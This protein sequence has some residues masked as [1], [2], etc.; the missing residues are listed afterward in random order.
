MVCT[1]P[2][3][4]PQLPFDL[5][6]GVRVSKLVLAQLACEGA[7]ALAVWCSSGDAAL[8]EAV[9]CGDDAGLAGTNSPTEQD[10]DG[11]DSQP[12]SCRVECANGLL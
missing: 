2:H 8:K 9:Y 4:V 12:L 10:V 11:L 3:A 6:L 7:C 5:S 1:P